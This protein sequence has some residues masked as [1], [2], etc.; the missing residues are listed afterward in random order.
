MNSSNLGFTEPTVSL[1]KPLPDI[2]I[3]DGNDSHGLGGGGGVCK[4]DG[5]IRDVEVL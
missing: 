3:M 1:L 5:P 4:D 2:T